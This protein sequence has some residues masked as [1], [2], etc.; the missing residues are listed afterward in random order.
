MNIGIFDFNVKRWSYGWPSGQCNAINGIRGSTYMYAYNHAFRS[1]LWSVVLDR[2]VCIH[3]KC[4]I[5]ERESNIL[6]E[7]V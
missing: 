1:K 3:S 2:S 4:E 6:K 5:Y 7:L